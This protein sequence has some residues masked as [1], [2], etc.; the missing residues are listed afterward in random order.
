MSMFYELMMRRFH[1][2]KNYMDLSVV[3][4][5]T[6]NNGVV[7]N[8][9]T[10]NYIQL[11]TPFAPSDKD[12]EIVIK[13]K[14]YNFSENVQQIF[15]FGTDSVYNSYSGIDITSAGRVRLI[16]KNIFRSDPFV[17]IQANTDVW[18]RLKREGNSVN[19]ATSSDGVNYGAGVSATVSGSLIWTGTQMFGL[20]INQRAF[21]G[22][23][24]F[25]NSY[26]IQDG[27]KYKFRFAIPL[28]KVG[29]PTIVDGVVSG[30]SAS[31]YFTFNMTQE[32]LQQYVTKS[33][34]VMKVNFTDLTSG[35]Q[36]LWLAY[37]GNSTG[38]QTTTNN[39][40][41]WFVTSSAPA[42]SSDVN[43]IALGDIWIK[44][45]IENNVATLFL[46]TDGK[47]WVNNNSTELQGTQPDL[48]Q[49]SRIGCNNT[50]L[51]FNGAIYIPQCYIKLGNTK[52]IF[53]LP[54]Q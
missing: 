49:A 48:N 50:T 52:Y 31:D 3:G 53:T 16:S 9:S 54:Q 27:T 45:V 36:I 22:E 14:C 37:K 18:V 5:P 38:F 44:G 7:S 12:F 6:I 29:N 40:I 46:S 25:N 1:S 39:R 23:I 20:R 47:N 10:S 26:I 43:S 33:E 41:R 42:F 2:A 35:Q 4:S 13:F 19:F 21:D 51:V 17:S 34:I 24:D 32:M 11:S 8:F 15:Y 30:F 28:N